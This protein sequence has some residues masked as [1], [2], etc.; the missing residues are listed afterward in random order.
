MLSTPKNQVK[1]VRVSFPPWL[2][3]LEDG[4]HGSDSRRVG[5]PHPLSV[6]G[7]CGGIKISVRRRGLVPLASVGWQLEVADTV[8]WGAVSKI[9]NKKPL[10]YFC[11]LSRYTITAPRLVRW[12]HFWMMMI[13][14]ILKRTKMWPPIM[15]CRGFSPKHYY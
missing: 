8:I 14:W 10:G 15:T 2:P 13:L 5:V 3:I 4:G 7:G 11:L 9:L 1:A 12:T 6:L